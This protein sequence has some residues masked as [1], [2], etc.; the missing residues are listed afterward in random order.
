[1]SFKI[2]QTVHTLS[3]F[4]LL[5][6]DVVIAKIIGFLAEFVFIV[7]LGFHSATK[8]RP[9]CSQWKIIHLKRD[10]RTS[11]PAQ[12]RQFSIRSAI[13][14]SASLSSDGKA[15][16]VVSYLKKYICIDLKIKTRQRRGIKTVLLSLIQHCLLTGLPCFEFAVFINQNCGIKKKK[17]DGTTTK[18]KARKQNTHDSSKK[19]GG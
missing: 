7:L 9:E 8:L 13:I 18:K 12:W 5:F 16:L 3:F 2:L 10:E 1:M 11:A 15:W 6:T 14:I 17:T 4:F 19:P